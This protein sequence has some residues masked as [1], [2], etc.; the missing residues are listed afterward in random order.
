[1]LIVRLHSPKDA[2]LL[3]LLKLQ[4]RKQRKIFQ[5]KRSSFLRQHIEEAENDGRTLW[6][7][8]NSILSPQSPLECPLSPDELL[9]HF[10]NKTEAICQST[11]DAP[12]PD[13][14]SNH[15]NFPGFIAFQ[16]VTSPEVDKLLTESSTKN[17]ELDSS[18]VWL[19]KSLRH[20]F[21]P[22]LVLLINCSLST[23][24]V[25][26]S[27][28]RAI[29]RPRIKKSDIDL[30]DPSNYRPISNPSFI[31]KLVERAVHKQLSHY[32]ES[33]SLLP[34]VQS[35][36]R[37]LHSTETVVLK[38]YNDIIL[39]LDSGFIIA[40]LLLDF[41]SAFD[42]VD[43]SNSILLEVIELQFGIT[44]SALLWIANFLTNRSHLVRLGSNSSKYFNIIIVIGVPRGSILGPLLFVL[45]TSSIIYITSKHDI[46]I[47]IYA[48]DT[49]L[50][51]KLSA[52]DIVNAKSR[53]LACFSDIQAWC[54][55][56]RLKL[57]ASKTE[58]IWF[59]RLLTPAT[60]IP[61]TVLNRGPD[62]SI[63][64]ADVVRD[65]G[66]LIDNTLSLKFQIASITKFCFFHLRRI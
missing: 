59:N 39:A 4:S 10:A 40:L 33:N 34:L 24:T 8:L 16:E 54:A 17:C 9:D 13:L 46:R 50:Y 23:C 14:N 20:V 60:D 3:N 15:M 7:A 28:K 18:P 44:A 22:I 38:V 19:I 30:F 62:C 53:L 21:V 55:S 45:Y 2:D 32:I 47:Q 37:R 36:F 11:K 26:T 64:P 31:S 1:M 5:Q 27:H 29:I 48:D 35:G 56:M 25:P 65:L 49:Q 42:C 6:K 41:S 51:I 52:K 63:K 58:L 57:N 66:V 43:H 12:A 61:H